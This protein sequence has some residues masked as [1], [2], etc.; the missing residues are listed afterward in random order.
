MEQKNLVHVTLWDSTH[1]SSA[2]QSRI[3]LYMTGN[4]WQ[5]CTDYAIGTICLKAPLPLY[6]Y[7]QTTPIFATIT[8]HGKS[9]HMLPGIYWN[10]NSITSCWST[11]QVRQIELMGS[12]VEKTMTPEAIQTMKISQYGQISISASST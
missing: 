7:T 8:T 9:D 2:Q 1:R 5:S 4:S 3:I 6:L 11:N 12:H 10:M